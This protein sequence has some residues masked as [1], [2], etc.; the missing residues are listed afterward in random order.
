MGYDRERQPDQSNLNALT[1][2]PHDSAKAIR[3]SAQQPA[4]AAAPSPDEAMRRDAE[5]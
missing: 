1:S 5:K 2:A 4:S 3:D